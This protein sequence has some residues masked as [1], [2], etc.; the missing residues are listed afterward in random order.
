MKSAAMLLLLIGVLCSCP[1]EASQVAGTGSESQGSIEEIYVGRNVRESRRSPSE[2]CSQTR[3][4]F[5]AVAEDQYALRSIVTRGA[6]GRMADATIAGIGHFHA[7][8]GTTSDPATLRFYAEGSVATISL[9]VV[10]DCRALKQDFPE[11]GIT[12]YACA[13]DVR[14]LPSD[15]VGG[16]VT[17]NTVSSRSV[18]GETSDPPGYTQPSIVTFRLWRRR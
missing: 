12:I 9:T 6:D 13:F 17:T 18:I 14:D 8:I 3:T 1:A 7:C 2:F 16:L 4:G 5:A 11:T 15:Y 10:G